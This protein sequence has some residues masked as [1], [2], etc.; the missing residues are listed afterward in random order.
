MAKPAR[1]EAIIDG[2]VKLL[3]TLE[4]KKA[5]VKP[6]D[7]SVPDHEEVEEPVKEAAHA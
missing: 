4:E 5:P 3:S 2:V 6:P 1:P 7:E